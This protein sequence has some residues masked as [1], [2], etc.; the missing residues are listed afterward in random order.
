MSAIPSNLARVPVSLSSQAMLSNL[1]RTSARLL[2]AQVQLASGRQVNK[3]SDNPIGASLMIALQ[4]SMDIRQQRFINY[5]RAE[6]LM[7]VADAAMGEATDIVLQARDIASQMIGIGGDPAT[8]RNQA[9]VI[10]AMINEMVDLANTKFGD[11]YLFGGAQTGQAP[12]EATLGGYRYTGADYGLSLDLGVGEAL[13]VTLPL[14]RAFGAMSSR[15]E[16]DRDLNPD[17]VGAT[18]VSDLNGARGLGVTLGSISIDVGGVGTIDVDLSSADSVQDVIDL[19]DNAIATLEADTSTAILGP[20]RVGINSTSNGLALDVLAGLTVT[21]TDVGAGTTAADLGLSQGS[22]TIATPDGADVDARLSMLTAIADLPGVSPLGDFIITNA[23]Q[24]RTVDTAGVTTLQDLANAIAR[25]GIGARLTISDNGERINVVSELSGTAMSISETVGGTSATDLGI[26]S[27]T[28]TTRLD[29]FNNGRGVHILSGSIDPQT[30][31]PDPTLDIDFRVHLSDGTFFDVDLA[32]AETVQ[33]VIDMVTAAAPPG[34]LSIALTDGPNGLTLTDLTGGAGAFRIESRNGSRAAEDLG[35]L[36]ESS[37][38]I[39]TGEDRATIE[40]DSVLTH[41]VRLRDALLADDSLG[42]TF[43]GEALTADVD[44]LAQA[45]AVLG[46]RSNR[47]SAI[48]TRE[49][50]RQL[51]D[52]SLMSQIRDLD[53]NEATIRFTSLQAQLQAAML[54]TSQLGSLSLFRFLG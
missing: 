51:L 18:R 48:R 41:L 16:G 49:E 24:T 36:V 23:G 12:I 26:R 8:R 37:G 29:A 17:L 47:V 2:E 6:S 21:F 45:R 52:Q 7:N 33:D 50:D 38:A 10:N 3:A 14:G 42:I 11:L 35:I 28:G 9:E 43:A 54:T 19:V 46:Q 22:F 13:E 32:G 1:T 25:T 27:F 44:R 39:L 15:V 5:D 30:G 40:V 31:L 20:G 4:R 34:T 53:Y